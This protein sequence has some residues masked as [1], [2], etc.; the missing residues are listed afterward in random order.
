MMKKA[1]KNLT[2]ACNLARSVEDVAA[3]VAAAY[4]HMDPVPG[5]YIAAE[6]IPYVGELKP[7]E[8]ERGRMRRR[9]SIR[10]KFRE[11]LSKLIGD[12][13]E[14]EDVVIEVPISIASAE[15][16]V[17]S[18]SSNREA[19]GVTTQGRFATLST[20]AGRSVVTVVMSY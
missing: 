7:E 17:T 9:E 6:P 5:P 18:Q 1:A 2:E 16:Y 8:A 15:A 3:L 14:C 11:E 10:L 20:I 4:G 12:L 13:P 19:L